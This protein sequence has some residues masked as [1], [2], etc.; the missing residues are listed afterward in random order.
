MLYLRNLIPGSRSGT[1]QSDASRIDS[2]DVVD[3]FAI[4]GWPCKRLIDQIAQK[5]QE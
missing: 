4:D 1:C 5:Q 3:S 2:G